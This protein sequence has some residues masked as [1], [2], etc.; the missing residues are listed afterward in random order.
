M[1]SQYVAGPLTVMRS[2]PVVG[3]VSIAI[4]KSYDG[5][6]DMLPLDSHRKSD[7]LREHDAVFKVRS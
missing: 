7:L 2:T 5:I 1:R 4:A 3:D 6:A